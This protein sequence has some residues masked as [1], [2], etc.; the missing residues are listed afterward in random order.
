M[1]NGVSRTVF[2]IDMDAFF[3]SVEQRDH[4]QYRGK[5]VIIGAKPGGRG[6]VSTASYEARKFG[7]HSAMPI[8]EAYS[9]CPHGIFIQPRML[10]Y[11]AVSRSI[12]TLFAHFSPCVEQV[13]VD[14]AFLDMTG[15]RRLLGSPLLAA[16]AIADAL[17]KQHHLTASIGIAPNKFCAKVASDCNKPDGITICPSD[18]QGVIEWLAP[19]EVRKIWG[20]GKITAGTLARAGVT[21]VGQLQQMQFDQLVDRFGRQGMALYYLARGVDDRP[22]ENGGPCKSISRE[23]TF[24]VD[25]H[26]RA[27]WRSTLFALSQD[28]ARHARRDGVKGRT[29]V[30]IWRRPDFSR[31]SRR[32]TLLQ[33]TNVA[34]FIFETAMQLLEKT[35]EPVLR[36]LGVGITGLGQPLQTDLFTGTAG[37][38]HIELSEQT[39][40]ALT[41]RFGRNIITKGYECTGR[42]R[43]RNGRVLPE[44]NH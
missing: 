12:M 36:L 23:H 30:L 28:V 27:R 18:P 40:D 39:V 8:G 3:A 26:D 32:V 33:P 14:E 37:F 17:K 9:R 41:E 24:P 31:H 19:M 22:V 42:N 10:V 34:R 20:V 5:P 38:S 6:V 2:H 11:E 44:G 1:D 43:R 35:G 4:P 7:I 21:T 29:V 25:S 16:R 13:S 15:T